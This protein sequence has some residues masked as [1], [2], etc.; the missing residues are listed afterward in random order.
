MERTPIAVFKTVGH[1]EQ[2]AI[3]N[4]AAGRDFSNRTSPSGNHASG[5]TGRST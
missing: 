2:I 3:V 4:N 5:D 1:I